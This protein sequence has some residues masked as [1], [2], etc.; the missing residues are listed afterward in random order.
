MAGVADVF[1]RQ[2]DFVA[3]W[4]GGALGE[5]TV[6]LSALGTELRFPQERGRFVHVVGTLTVDELATIAGSMV[7]T[8]GAGLV[9]L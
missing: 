2:S 1:V 4:Q 8:E 5:G 6:L 7:A 3:V 9:Y